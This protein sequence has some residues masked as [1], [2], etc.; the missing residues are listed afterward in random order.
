[1]K[2]ATLSGMIARKIMV[3]PCMVN[4]SLYVF[5]FT[6]PLSGRMSWARMISASMPP[7]R[8]KAKADTPYIMP[9]RL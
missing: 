5:S 4:S 8:K 1:L 9:I 6:T 7:S 2:K 3:V